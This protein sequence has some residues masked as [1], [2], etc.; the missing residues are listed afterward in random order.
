MH[1]P[2]LVIYPEEYAEIRSILTQLASEAKAKL[3]FLVDR[4][5]QPIAS[6]GDN[7]SVDTTSL[8]SLAAGNVAA[9]E[10]LAQ[11]LGEREFSVLFHEGERDNIHFS[12]VAH[13]AILVVIFDNRTPVGL[14]RLRVRQ[15]AAQFGDVFQRVV[16]RFEKDM[17]AIGMKGESPFPEITDEDIDRLFVE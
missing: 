11:L 14:V 10:G 8:S 7:G 1:L 5:G 16:E 6:Y 12:I 3:V 13:R 17:L 9:T 4:N 2:D 15:A